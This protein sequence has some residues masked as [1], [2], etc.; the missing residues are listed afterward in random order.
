[1]III[2]YKIIYFKLIKDIDDN[3]PSVNYDNEIRPVVLTTDIDSCVHA[4]DAWNG[5]LL[6]SIKLGKPIV[7]SKIH[8]SNA[9]PNENDLRSIFIL[10]LV[11]SKINKFRNIIPGL[12]GSIYL[13]YQDALYR[14]PVTTQQ[15]I[16]STNYI[17]SGIED[18]N[19]QILYGDKETIIF[20]VSM[21]DGSLQY[22]LKGDYISQYCPVLYI[23]YLV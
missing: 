17:I 13:S 4:I 9:N 12:D 22:T 19:D 1:M 2:L 21:N 20:A 11:T 23:Y 14:L 10:Y 8:V 5:K 3:L 16:S 15:I 18:E 6:W 7:T